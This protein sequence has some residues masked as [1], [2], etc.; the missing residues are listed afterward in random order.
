M[1]TKTHFGWI[2]QTLLHMGS[3]RFA[4][5]AIAIW[6]VDLLALADG[7]AVGEKREHDAASSCAQDGSRTWHN[8]LLS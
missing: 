6:T 1:I 5:S 3:F 8:V 7:G 4:R 2:A